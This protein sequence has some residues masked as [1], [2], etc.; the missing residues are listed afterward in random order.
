LGAIS[1]HSFKR[2]IV[3]ADEIAFAS[4]NYILGP[5]KSRLQREIGASHAEFGLLIAAYTLNS[6][7]TPLV[8]GVVASRL[9]TTVTSI[10]AT[11]VI[12][13]GALT[14]APGPM[15]GTQSLSLVGQIILLI[16]D[17]WGDVRLMVLGLFVFGMGVSPLAVV[18]ETIIVRFFK[19]HGLGVSM[20]LGLVAGKGASFV[21]ARTSY[22][23]AERFGPRAPFYVATSLAGLSV[24]VNLIYLA[25]SKWLVDGAGAELEAPDIKEEAHRREMFDV[26]EAQ[27]L[28]KVAK[29]RYVDIRQVA[30]LGDAFWA[31]VDAPSLMTWLLTAV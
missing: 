13:F 24:I 19:S 8:G 20:A 9:G 6:T 30:K 12:F 26:S 7:W 21:A 3:R 31:Y 5:L 1:E 4:A 14:F 15:N 25:C 18:Q 22:P 11:G 17:I 28:E 16:G 23:L 27:A 29:K 10:L 2:F